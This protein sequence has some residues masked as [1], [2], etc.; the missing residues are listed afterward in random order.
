KP[1]KV[2]RPLEMNAEPAP[3][4]PQVEE[5]PPKAEEATQSADTK[6]ETTEETPSPEVIEGGDEVIYDDSAPLDVDPAKLIRPED[7]AGWE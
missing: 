5:T 2:A 4:P 1:S 6:T 3:Q 7:K